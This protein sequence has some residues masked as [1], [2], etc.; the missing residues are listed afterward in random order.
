M[1]SAL[2]IAQFARIVG[3][4]VF[5]A[6]LG[7]PADAPLPEVLTDEQRGRARALAGECAGQVAQALLDEAMASD[8]IQ[9]I[10]AAT[11]Y[12]EERLRFLGLLLDEETGARIRERFLAVARTWR[13]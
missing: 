1:P 7:L 9:D 2:A 12:L 11:A 13:S 10:A 3:R 4:T 8:D 6:R 5:A